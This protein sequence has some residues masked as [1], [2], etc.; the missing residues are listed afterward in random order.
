MVSSGTVNSDASSITSS[1]SKF[2]S[3]ISETA[4]SWKGNSHDKFESNASSFSSEFSGALSGQM[5][6]F[7]NACDLY[8]QYITTKSNYNTAASNYDAAVSAGETSNANTF[9]ARMNSYK[10]S[11][12]SL[13]SQITDILSSV[14]SVKLEASPI[15]PSVSLPGGIG[16]NSG[17]SGGVQG[18]IDWALSVADNDAH[19]YSQNT[20]WGNPNYDCSSLI[21]SAYEE[22]GIPVKTNGATY[23]GDMRRAFM[24][25]GFDCYEYGSVDLKPGDV[26]LRNGHTEMYIG[27]GK[28]VGAHS[29]KD[30]VDGDSSGRE[31]NVADNGGNWT[32]VL[33][34]NGVSV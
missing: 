18:A 10:A 9:S 17:V 5:S 33:R 12:E 25:T 26:L 16:L 34:Y 27:D 2:N 21:I 3:A 4:S 32:W 7:A 24:N 8:N 1:L 23:T 15:N 29:N 20:R 13:K 6:S 22:A 19:G 30:G 31:I 28:N 14:S 11:M